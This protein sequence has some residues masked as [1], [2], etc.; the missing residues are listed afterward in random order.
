[1]NKPISYT[2]L[3]GFFQNHQN[4][5]DLSVMT[6]SVVID[7]LQLDKFIAQ[8][9]NNPDCDAVKIYFIRYPLQQDEDHI[10]TPGNNLSQ[11]SLAIVPAKFIDD[12]GWVYYDWIAKDLKDQDGINIFTLLVCEPGYP[13][14]KTDK[15][16]LC[17]PKGTCT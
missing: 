4:N 3:M 17:P 16:S 9:K 13:R 6:N 8:A 15:N 10:K 5:P 2:Q 11:I 1:M 7:L 14:D 12:N